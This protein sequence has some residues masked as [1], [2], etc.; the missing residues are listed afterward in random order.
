MCLDMG[1]IKIIRENTALAVACCVLYVPTET[2]VVSSIERTGLRACLCIWTNAFVPFIAGVTV[3]RTAG[4]LMQPAPVS[5]VVWIILTLLCIH[6]SS[7]VRVQN[8]LGTL[9]RAATTF[10]A[11]WNLERGVIFCCVGPN[12]LSASAINQSEEQSSLHLHM[13]VSTPGGWY[14]L[15][16]RGS[17]PPRGQT[18]CCC[19]GVQLWRLC[20]NCRD[21]CA[22]RKPYTHAA[23][24]SYA[25]NAQ[26]FSEVLAC[27]CL[28]HHVVPCRFFFFPGNFLEVLKTTMHMYTARSNIFEEW[29]LKDGKRFGA[30]VTG[31]SYF[32][33]V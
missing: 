17:I 2:W 20:A 29:L 9:G 18:F 28:G 10:S 33:S 24:D 32:S 13:V 25:T 6:A 19:N 11:C 31:A 12:K 23:N 15:R 16:V 14:Q 4:T 3:L 30:C 7:P 26:R 5:S 27:W 1:E 21:W 8:Y 22:K